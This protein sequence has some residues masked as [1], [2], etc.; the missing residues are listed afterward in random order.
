MS[1]YPSGQV[2]VSLRPYI[3][4]TFGPYAP[5]FPFAIF[6]SPTTA[7]FMEKAGRCGMGI[8]GGEGGNWWGRKDGE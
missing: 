1:V 2:T 7:I 6:S 8:E 3:A 5:T 4:V